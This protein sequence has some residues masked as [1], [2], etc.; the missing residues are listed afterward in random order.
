[1]N[2]KK[3]WL[4]VLVAIWCLLFYFSTWLVLT[5]T[6]YQLDK[7]TGD[8]SATTSSDIRFDFNRFSS[9]EGILQKVHY[10][11]WALNPFYIP[12]SGWNVSLIFKEDEYFY[13]LKSKAYPRRDVVR[14]FPELDFPSD[15]LGFFGSF[16]TIA[17]DDGVYELF[18]KLEEPDSDPIKISTNKFYEKKSNAF[19]EVE[20]EVGFSLDVL[21][22]L[23]QTTEIENYVESCV[24]L[25]NRL[26][27]TGWGFMPGQDA[28]KDSIQLRVTDGNDQNYYFETE[29]YNRSDVS[30][31]FKNDEYLFSGF[32]LN[33]TVEKKWVMP[34][35][36]SVIIN[37][38][39]LAEQQFT[40]SESKNPGK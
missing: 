30:N 36:V 33:L 8:I 25:E 23:A 29:K 20:R 22:G 32:T 39:Y 13:E 1:M 28:V 31:T 27:A 4:I 35:T 9:P 14:A 2:P 34:V 3:K 6:G 10:E 26:N 38:T 40:C 16:S 19:F 17:I 11:G 37:E 18:I 7:N 21:P 15:D 5:A 12:A 24:I